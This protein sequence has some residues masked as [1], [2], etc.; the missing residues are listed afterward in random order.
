MFRINLF[1]VI[2]LTAASV[3]FAQ[4]K[5]IA[6]CSDQGTSAFIQ[7]FVM[8]E[9]GSDKKQL[10]NINENCMKPRW[11]PDGKQIVFYSDK[12]FVYLIR[13]VDNL[14]SDYT[15]LVWNGIYPSF[16][17]DGNEIMFN[18]EED[19]VLSIFV[20]DTTQFGAQPEIITDG[21]YSNMQ[22]LSPDGK[23]V[24][25]SAFLDGV[26]TI[27]SADLEDE[28]DNYIKKISMNND[29]NL[30]PD[31]SP[32]GKKIAYASFDNNLNGTV[33]IYENGKETALTKGI[34]S[35]NVP[36]FSPDGKKI[37]FV[38]ISDNNVDLY[39]MNT[40]GSDKK[41]LDVKGGNVGTFQW[42]DDDKIV[43]DAGSDT[44]ISIGIVN[45]K[46]GISEIIADGGF[47]LQPCATK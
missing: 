37:A 25:Y 6:Y 33:R 24:I 7:I 11:S 36:R 46:T 20:I 42:L 39:T 8:N 30:E 38:V 3:T 34:T 13:N 10:T 2:L 14:Y 9:D 35:A 32:D 5:K 4:K 41:N 44:R 31:I 27:M 43:Y 18:T 23:K 28:S 21:S 29:A 15:F 17:P 19:D 22:V 12:G 16:M 26:K 47:N 45:T 1:I 40:D